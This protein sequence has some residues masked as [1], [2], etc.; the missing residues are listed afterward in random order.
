MQLRMNKEKEKRLTFRNV[1]GLDLS[2]RHGTAL[3]GPRPGLRIAMWKLSREI[4]S[5]NALFLFQM[6]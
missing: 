1:R 5:C 6:K 4:L 3:A 2:P